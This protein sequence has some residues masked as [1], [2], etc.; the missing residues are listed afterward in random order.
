MSDRVFAATRKGLVEFR[1][2]GGGW[3]IAN[4]AFLGS[5]VNMTLADPRD[6]TL[7]AALDLGHFGVKMHRSDDDGQAWEEIASPSYEGFGEGEDAPSL[8]LIWALETGGP[9]EPG[10]LWA[11]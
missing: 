10:G 1:R 2:N 7:Y 6:G 4:T 8:K 11:G 9:D 3:G 5:P